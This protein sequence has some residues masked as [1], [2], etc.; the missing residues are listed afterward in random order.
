MYNRYLLMYNRYSPNTSTGN[1]KDPHT[2]TCGCTGG[3]TT[4]Q[5]GEK[6]RANLIR[7]RWKDRWKTYPKVHILLKNLIYI[8]DCLHWCLVLSKKTMFQTMTSVNWSL[9]TVQNSYCIF[10][11][12]FSIL[13]SQNEFSKQIS[14]IG[15]NNL[16]TVI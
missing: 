15:V 16:S 12:H 11:S 3:W 14:C 2:S 5:F 9:N 4:I 1:A 7:R 8:L 13:I 6:K 10:Q